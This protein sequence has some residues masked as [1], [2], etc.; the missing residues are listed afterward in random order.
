[1]NHEEV[2]ISVGKKWGASQVERKPDW[3]GLEVWELLF[4]LPGEEIPCTGYPIF[5]VFSDNGYHVT[6]E[7]EALE[8][9]NY[10]RDNYE[11]DDDGDII[12]YDQP[13]PI[14]IG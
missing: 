6:D 7:D 10:L 12:G 14:V 9:L 5:V 13:E 4:Y 3:N 1:M 8:Y 11:F 2:A